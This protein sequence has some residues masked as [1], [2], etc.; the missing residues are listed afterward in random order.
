MDN[1]L[2]VKR[3]HVGVENNDPTMGVALWNGVPF[4]LTLERPW[5]DNKSSISCIPTGT[6]HC[7]RCSNSPDYAFG[8]SPQFGDTFQVYQV[9]GRSKILFHKGNIDDDTHGCILLGEQYQPLGDESAILSSK[10]AFNEFK[11]LTNGLDEFILIV[12]DVSGD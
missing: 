10:A 11:K 2:K 5:L 1:T 4:C 9:P 3:V 12:Q 8:N 6:Y 7:L